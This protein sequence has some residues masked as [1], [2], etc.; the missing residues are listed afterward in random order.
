MEADIEFND[1]YDGKS[2]YYKKIKVKD[3]LNLFRNSNIL[4]IHNCLTN[5]IID[6]IFVDENSYEDKKQSCITKRKNFKN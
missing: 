5:N 1:L 3:F 4:N 2:T 6:E